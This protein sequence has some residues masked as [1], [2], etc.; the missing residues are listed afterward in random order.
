MKYDV[1]RDWFVYPL[2]AVTLGAGFV[3]LYVNLTG[4]DMTQQKLVRIILGLALMLLGAYSFWLAVSTMYEITATHVRARM[5]PFRCEVPLDAI[6]R[7]IIVQKLFGH[8]PTRK[9]FSMSL[10][11]IYIEY[12]RLSDNTALFGMAISPKDKARF[13]HDLREAAPH[14]KT[15]ESEAT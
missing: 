3:A 13:L 2:V 5:G 9:N 4:P 6:T 7:V 15:S 10:D 1:K 14:L 12:R 8:R 11:R